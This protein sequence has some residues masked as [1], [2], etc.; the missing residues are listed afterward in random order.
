DPA[1]VDRRHRPLP[2]RHRDRLRAG[3]GRGRLAVHAAGLGDGD[4]GGRRLHRLGPP[5]LTGQDAASD[6]TGLPFQTTSNFEILS[7]GN[8][9]TISTLYGCSDST[10]HES[11]QRAA[12]PSFG[13]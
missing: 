12:L 3:A 11:I 4:A 13:T 9:T 10:G 5:A 8:G 7:R 2:A 6:S 1:G